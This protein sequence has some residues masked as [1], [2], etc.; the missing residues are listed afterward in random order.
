MIEFFTHSEAF[1][2]CQLRASLDHFP[3]MHAFVTTKGDVAS[4]VLG[5]SGKSALLL[6]TDLGVENEDALGASNR[7]SVAPFLFAGRTCQKTD[8]PLR[9]LAPL[10]KKLRRTPAAIAFFLISQR[11]TLSV[12]LCGIN[13]AN[14]APC[15]GEN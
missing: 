5:K 14:S 8:F 12:D 3:S 7:A 2:H 15:G 6:S 13:C 11:H 10:H 1:S 9:S 4:V